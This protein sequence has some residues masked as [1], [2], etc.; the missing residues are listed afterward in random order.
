M[1]PSSQTEMNEA[2]EALKANKDVWANLDIQERINILD[3]IIH[4]VQSVADRWISAGIEAQD[5][6]A[7]AYGVGEKNVTF[8]LVYR[9][10]RLF[11]QSLLDI[12]QAGNPR[13]PGPVHQR[14]NGQVVAQVFPQT[15]YDKLSMLGVR[16]E[17]W[18]MPNASL[19]NGKPAQASFYQS[20]NREGK[21]ALVLGAGNL[22]ALIVAD[23]MHKLFVEGQVVVLKPNPVNDYIGPLIEEGF[24]GLIK[25]NFMRVVYGG[26]TEGAFLVQHP[27]VDEIHMTGSDRTFEAI[28]FGPGEEGAKRKAARTPQ[29][30]KP[31]TAELGNISPVIVVPGP[32]KSS[33][34]QAQVAKVGTF[35]SSNAGCACLTPRMII[36]WQ[37]WEQRQQLNES[38]GNYLSQLQT[39]QAYYPGTMDIHKQFLAEHPDA[40]QLGETSDGHLPWTFI[41]DV[42]ETHQED[43][44]FRQEGFGSLMAE[45]GLAAES[46]EAFIE[47]AVAFANETLWGNLVATILVHPKS[48]KDPKIE[49]AVNRAI[50]NLRYG[51]VVVNH[52][53]VMAYMLTVTSWGAYPGQDI[54]DI[55]SGIGTVNNVLMF[56]HPQKSVVYYPFIQKPDPVL[57]TS[58]NI[59]DFG[60]KF[61]DFQLSPSFMTLTRLLVSAMKS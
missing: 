37:Q 40:W 50:A 51:S 26:G 54:Y 9:I 25:R 14:E 35:F 6:Q 46:A 18:M 34:I 10:V 30:T 5:L 15:L 53:G 42:D 59:R 39:R 55:Q 58:R 12:Q 57:T 52:L 45:T 29:T 60:K 22:A 27:L 44:C 8:S 13:I 19:E 38:L 23:F 61:V 2:V 43:I 16:A 3:E 21:V 56:D 32:W 49:T 48:M 33:D 7:N 24:R 11:R 17:I 1:K 36:N 28:V 41:P 20:K 31:I 4:D 47:K